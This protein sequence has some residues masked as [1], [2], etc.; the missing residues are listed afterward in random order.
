MFTP[1]SGEP[2][3]RRRGA[4]CNRGMSA[5]IMKP[6]AA[7]LRQQPRRRPHLT[8]QWCVDA[9]TMALTADLS[10][11]WRII[12]EKTRGCLTLTP[13]SIR[14]ARVA[15]NHYENHN[16]RKKRNVNFHICLKTQANKKKNTLF[17][18]IHL[19][20]QLH[21]NCQSAVNTVEWIMNG[22]EGPLLAAEHGGKLYPTT[23]LDSTL[24]NAAER[25]SGSSNGSGNSQYGK[26]LKEK[27]N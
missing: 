19:P 11:L 23:C 25:N 9:L 3:W 24:G 2:A 4:L 7:P 22:D 15:V 6:V 27:K 12:G 16:R 17:S 13:F 1:L 5:A 21:P 20:L 26:S 14:L 10:A 18:S 8:P